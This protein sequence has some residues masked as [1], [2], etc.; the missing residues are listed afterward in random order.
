MRPDVVAEAVRHAIKDGDMTDDVTPR[1]PVPRGRAAHLE[2]P[3]KGGDAIRKVVKSE[4]EGEIHSHSVDDMVVDFH[5]IGKGR[6]RQPA[7]WSRRCRR[8]GCAAS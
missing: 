1:P 5:E 3:F 6:R 2:L 8:A 7:C 4:V